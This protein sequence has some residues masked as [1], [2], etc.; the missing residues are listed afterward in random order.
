M[1]VQ[2]QVRHAIVVGSKYHYTQ[3]RHGIPSYD[4]NNVVLMDNKGNLEGTRILAPIPSA[5]RVKGNEPM[6]AKLLALATK[7]VWFD[8]I[9]WLICLL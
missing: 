7:F 6:F 9:D 1:A 5:L 3:M 8:S 2:G 4:S